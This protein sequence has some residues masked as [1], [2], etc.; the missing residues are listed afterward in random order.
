MKRAI[1]L[2]IVSIFTLGALSAAPA[3]ADEA[4]TPTDPCA[5]QQAQY[6]RAVAKWEHLQAKFQEHPSKKAK[7]AK[8]AQAQRVEHAL[9][10]LDACKADTTE[11]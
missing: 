2:S 11:S 6:D 10:R 5:T 3:V 4:P 1:A 9:A 8:K 7:K